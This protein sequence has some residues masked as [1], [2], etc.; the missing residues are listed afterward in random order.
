MRLR[1]RR[2]IATVFS[3][4]GD[5]VAGR[6]ESVGIEN[7]AQ[8]GHRDGQSV[9]Q[10]I[11]ALVR[12]HHV[13]EPF[14]RHRT[15]EGG[16]KDLEQLARLLRLPGRA[17]DLLAVA[18]DLEPSECRHGQR[19]LPI[20]CGRT[21]QSVQVGARAR[22]RRSDA[23]PVR[24]AVLRPTG[25]RWGDAVGRGPP[26]RRARRDGHRSGARRRR[27]RAAGTSRAQCRSGGRQRPAARRPR[28][29]R[30]SRGAA[31]PGPRPRNRARRRA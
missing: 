6:A 10:P 3:P 13:D 27:P 14:A 22:G 17:V 8:R 29:G 28:R 30:A 26:A 4:P 9:G 19:R 16:H 20:E 11:A 7:A 31:P 24:T 12:P 15:S 21:E 1:C 25:R 18:R 23:A 5:V 2:S